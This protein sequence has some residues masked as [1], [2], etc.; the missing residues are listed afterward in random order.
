M[1]LKV[2][3]VKVLANQLDLELR[4]TLKTGVRHLGL[5]GGDHVLRDGYGRVW[6]VDL[7]LET[8]TLCVGLAPK[9]TRF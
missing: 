4:D 5:S 8:C 2:R 3:A 1:N 7:V 9:V 6:L